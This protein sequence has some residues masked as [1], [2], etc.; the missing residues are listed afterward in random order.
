[1]GNCYHSLGNGV[2]FQ[3]VIQKLTN[4]VNFRGSYFSHFTTFRQQIFTNFRMLF[5][6]VVI[7]FIIFILFSNFVHNAIGFFSPLSNDHDL[8]KSVPICHA[9]SK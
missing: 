3:Y 8:L 9:L 2:S 4:F 5:N 1:M 7:N 6:A